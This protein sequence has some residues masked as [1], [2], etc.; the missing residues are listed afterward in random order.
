VFDGHGEHAP[1]EPHADV[2]LPG[3]HTPLPPQQPPLHGWLA[4]HE[5]VQ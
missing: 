3:A 5:V 2:E 1:D 4:V